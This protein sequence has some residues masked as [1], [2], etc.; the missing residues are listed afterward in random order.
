MVQIYEDIGLKMF[1]YHQRQNVLILPCWIRPQH[2]LL[3]LFNTGINSSYNSF[4]SALRFSNLIF[5]AENLIRII[6][7]GSSSSK[8]LSGLILIL[9]SE[10]ILI[11]H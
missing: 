10:I 1:Q 6:I 4:F 9:L 7:S 2:T 3:Q 8:L 11:N 5:Q